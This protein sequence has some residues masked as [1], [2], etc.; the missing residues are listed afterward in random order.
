MDLLFVK[1]LPSGSVKNV[2]DFFCPLAVG[3]FSCNATHFVRIRTKTQAG[4]TERNSK[5]GS[6]QQVTE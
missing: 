3:E 6:V 2:T 1:Y 5:A 4:S